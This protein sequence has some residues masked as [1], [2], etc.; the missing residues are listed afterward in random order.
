[1]FLT[2]MHSASFF[3]PLKTQKKG[4]LMYETFFSHFTVSDW[5]LRSIQTAG[6][7]QFV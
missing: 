5:G 1:M 3:F 4:L 7:D 6:Q 2:L